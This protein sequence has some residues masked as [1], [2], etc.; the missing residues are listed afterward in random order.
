M[1]W[2]PAKDLKKGWGNVREE[3]SGAWDGATGGG[4]N[5]NNYIN[6]VFPALAA[7][8]YA[9]NSKESNSN[10]MVQVAGMPDVA[11]IQRR[12]LAAAARQRAAEQQAQKTLAEGTALQRE[13]RRKQLALRASS[14]GYSGTRLTSMLGAGSTGAA[15][16]LG[17]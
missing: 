13:A 2:N 1:G 5:W 10:A 4:V 6:Y 16:L 11:L 14:A 8:G 7:T 17:A 3:A 12:G 15:T 9:L